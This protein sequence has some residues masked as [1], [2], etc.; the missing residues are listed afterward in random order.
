MLKIRLQRHGRNKRPFYRIVVCD[1]RMR[2]DGRFLEILGYYNPI[3]NPFTVNV[4]CE[5]VKKWVH[6]GAKPTVTVRRLIEK[7]VPNFFFQFEEHKRNKIRLARKKRK[8]RLRSAVQG[9]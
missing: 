4:D 6:H 8:E 2:R 5:A 3:T 1:E 9:T 7:Q